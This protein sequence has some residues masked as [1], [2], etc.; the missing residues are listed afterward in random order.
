MKFYDANAIVIN[1]D[2]FNFIMNY[3]LFNWQ[4][5]IYYSKCIVIL[6]KKAFYLKLERFFKD[7][8]FI[9]VTPYYEISNFSLDLFIELLLKND[10]LLIYHLGTIKKYFK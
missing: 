3:P 6:D 8:I 1:D 7:N 4:H 9:E 5:F 10:E 2:N